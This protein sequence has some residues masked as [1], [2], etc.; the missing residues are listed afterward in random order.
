MIEPS[1]EPPYPA[2]PPSVPPDLVRLSGP[3]RVQAWATVAA[4][5]G[6]AILYL[7]LAVWFARTAWRFLRGGADFGR[8]LLGLTSLFLFAFLVKGLFFVRR[9]NRLDS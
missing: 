7:G 1:G 4:L 8:I 3:Y 9:G 6:F 5:V 2:S